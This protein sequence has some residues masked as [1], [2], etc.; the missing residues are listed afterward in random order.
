MARTLQDINH[1]IQIVYSEHKTYWQEK[2]GE[3]KRY[4]DSYET[5]FWESEAYDNTMIRI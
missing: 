1:F 5:K 2:A 4:K 3:L